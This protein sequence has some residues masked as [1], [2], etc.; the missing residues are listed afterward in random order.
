MMAVL[1]VTAA[2]D[3]NA[4]LMF[5]GIDSVFTLYPSRDNSVPTES[6]SN[7]MM[8]LFNDTTLLI[9]CEYEMMKN[10]ERYVSD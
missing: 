8:M 5:I 7:N 1:I 10:E 6:M 3:V 2:G 4:A 9:D